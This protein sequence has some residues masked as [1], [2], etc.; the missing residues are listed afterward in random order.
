MKKE[1]L[2][3]L[4]Q[5]TIVF[6]IFFGVILLLGFILGQ[7]DEIVYLK[8][9]LA[10]KPEVIYVTQID[11]TKIMQIQAERDSLKE[12]LFIATYKLKRIKEYVKL[13]ERGTNHRFLAGWVNRVLDEHEE[14]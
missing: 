2:N 9:K 12:E 1:F 4:K 5:L 13:S 7:R 14:F 8:D 3:I 10:T 11:S 6:S